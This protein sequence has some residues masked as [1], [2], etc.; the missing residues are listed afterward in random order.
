MDVPR[1]SFVVESALQVLQKR[2][3]EPCLR[4][5]APRHGKHAVYHYAG[6]RCPRTHLKYYLRPL[7]L[8]PD[9]AQIQVDRDVKAQASRGAG[10]CGSHIGADGIEKRR[11]GGWSAKALRGTI[12]P[13]PGSVHSTMIPS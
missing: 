2:L 13:S 11:L 3:Q 8:A 6:G 12:A 1:S 7:H 9:W 10:L 5:S 4:G